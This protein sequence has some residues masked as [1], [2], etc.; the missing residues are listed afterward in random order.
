MVNGAGVLPDLDQFR[1]PIRFLT[2][3]FG[4]GNEE[5]V[6]VALLRQLAVRAFRRSERVE[7]RPNA[8]VL[9]AVGLTVEDARAMHRLLAL[10]HYHER[11]VIPTAP[12]E[13]TANAPYIERGFSG[14]R[15]MA[16]WG[17]PRRRSSFHGGSP[18][19]GS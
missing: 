8:D 6:R 15:E 2:R 19:V 5:V 9:T 10:A 14:F 1:I 16:V 18:E 3:L 7:R 11:Y 13:R 4:A 12:R 17:S